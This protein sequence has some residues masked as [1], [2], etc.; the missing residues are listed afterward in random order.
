MRIAIKLA[1]P[2]YIELYTFNPA[3]G[4]CM[5]KLVILNSIIHLAI[6]HTLLR[7]SDGVVLSPS[8]AGS[9]AAL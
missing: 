5:L 3:T 9:S 6:F 8:L 1:R 4:I 7:V 2:S